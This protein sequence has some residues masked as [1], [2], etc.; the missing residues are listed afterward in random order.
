[1]K[2]ADLHHEPQSSIR[3]RSCANCQYFLED[4]HTCEMS[5][6]PVTSKGVCILHEPRTKDHVMEDLYGSD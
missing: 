1:M 2:L 3:D 6:E 4:G 5:D